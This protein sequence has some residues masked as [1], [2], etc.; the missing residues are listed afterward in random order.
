M[1]RLSHTGSDG[2]SFVDRANRAGYRF[3]ALAENVAAG[4]NTAQS[5]F[6]G[7]MNSSGHRANILGANYIHMG[8]ACAA[9]NTNYCTQM[10][11]APA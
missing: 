9:S 6:D 10:F 1:Q 7:W 5:V 4:Y 11:G 8:A 2:S 3:R